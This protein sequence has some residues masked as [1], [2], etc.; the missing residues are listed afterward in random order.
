MK[1]ILILSHA[2]NM[3]GRAASQTITDKIPY[4]LVEQFQLFVLSAITGERDHRFQHSQ[5][6]AW[7][8]SAFRFDFRHWLA[9]RCGR[10]YIY[11]VLTGFV[12]LLLVPFIAIEK[13]LIGLSSQWSWSI[14]AVIRGYWQIKNNKVDVIYSTGGA[15]SAHLAGWILKK[16]TGC[17]LISE[18]HDPL[19]VRHSASDDGS[20][21]RSSRDQKFQQWLEKKLSRDADLIWWFTEGALGFAKKRNPSLGERGFFLLPGVESPQKHYQH[22]FGALF[23]IGH[24]GSL[25]DSRSLEPVLRALPFLFDRYPDARECLKI[26]IYGSGLDGTS[27]SVVQELSLDSVLVVHGRLEYDSITQL[28]GRQQIIMHMQTSDVL[29]LLH[30]NYEGCA[31]YIP[32]KLYEYWWANRPIMACTH[33]NPQL[34]GL[35]SEINGEK[36]SALLAHMGNPGEIFDALEF[37]WLSWL[38]K[39]EFT[40][41]AHPLGVKQAVDQIIVRLRN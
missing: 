40:H 7:G 39:K 25:A 8:P 32:S 18:I 29:L 9:M 5:L 14:P 4:L 2:F 17:V 33:L 34:D 15:W 30:G 36:F 37:A 38:G 21:R 35:I 16:M 27:K 26:N 13:I 3:D 31:E 1:K 19:V 12:S 22:E 11:K 20:S 28:S 6:I 10:G 41:H 23:N 24:F